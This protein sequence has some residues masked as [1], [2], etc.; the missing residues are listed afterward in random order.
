MRPI[1][2]LLVAACR[3]TAPTAP[4][5]TADA[6]TEGEAAVVS[7]M[8]AHYQIAEDLREALIQGEPGLV[9]TYARK[10]I[11]IPTVENP[12]V[13][14]RP[15]L[16]DTKAAAAAIVDAGTVEDAGAGLGSLGVSCATCHQAMEGGPKHRAAG[17][18]AETAPFSGM[19]RHAFAAESMWM[20][21]ITPNDELFARG[22]QILEN[23]ELPEGEAPYAL[24]Q[25]LSHVAEQAELAVELEQKG[26]LYGELV[27]TCAECH[28]AAVR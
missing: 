25:K 1:V 4:P 27:A 18:M 24:A 12:S 6:P 15:F 5:Q 3:S 26:A 9:S 10:L 23:P 16:S 2:L 28:R 8:S 17:M 14:W 13:D 22:A 11:D 20:G 21:L 7:T 19:T